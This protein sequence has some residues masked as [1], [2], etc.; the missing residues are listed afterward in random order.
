M[1]STVPNSEATQFKSGAIA[2][3]CGRKGG[4]ASGKS[5]RKKATMLSVLEKTLDE[6]N[7][8]GLTYRELV[9]L[10]LIK[11]AMNGSSKN[12]ELITNMMEQKEKKESEQQVFV[13]I[14][15]KDIASSFS[16]INRSI[17]DR[18]YREY[19]LEGGRGSTK[20]SFVSEKI[21]EIL[22]NN[23]KMCA[24]VL[25]KVKD[26]LKDSVYAQLEWAID[27]LSETYPHIKSDYKLTKS[28][29]EITKQSTGQKIYFRGA[30]DY[31]KMKRI[32][33]KL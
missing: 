20:S 22:E 18:E 31:G 32:D 13:T 26:T 23:P 29:L 5:K 19:Y 24:V 11:G 12:Y 16:D 3:E 7:N 21:I 2:V 6:T 8:K 27:T 33:N 14:P 17:D 30:D 28:P 10:G 1:A 15:A 4:I 9:T 25:R